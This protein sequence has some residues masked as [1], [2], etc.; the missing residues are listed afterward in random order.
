MVLL[1]SYSTSTF[2]LVVMLMSLFSGGVAPPLPWKVSSNG[3]INWDSGC[4]VQTNGAIVSRPLQT[5]K[6]SNTL[7]SVCGDLCFAESRCTHFNWSKDKS[8]NLILSDAFY[9]E[10]IKVLYAPSYGLCGF[11]SGRS[12]WTG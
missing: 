4:Y 7:S 9:I 3:V 8:C 10:G 11:A 5:K 6:I 2:A 1:S 12:R